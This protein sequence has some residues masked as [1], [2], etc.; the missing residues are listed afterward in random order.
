MREPVQAL[1]RES[2]QAVVRELVRELVQALARVPVPERSRRF[3][4]A[5]LTRPAP[6]RLPH[7]HTLQEPSMQRVLPTECAWMP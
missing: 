2:V 5:G 4:S 3:R 7:R 6:R 1:M